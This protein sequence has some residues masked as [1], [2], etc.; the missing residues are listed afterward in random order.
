V[1]GASPLCRTVD[2]IPPLEKACSK[3]TVLPWM[4]K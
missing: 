2:V 1:S 3:G 4:G